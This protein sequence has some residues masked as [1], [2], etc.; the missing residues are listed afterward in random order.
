M[1]RREL[2][3]RVKERQEL[4]RRE[5]R[6][7]FSLGA[8]G[9]PHSDPDRQGRRIIPVETWTRTSGQWS[10][11]LQPGISRSGKRIGFPYG[12]W[13]RWIWLWMVSTAKLTGSPVIDLGRSANQFLENL[14][15]STGGNSHARL[16]NHLTRMAAV[17]VTLF[18]GP[19]DAPG[20]ARKDLSVQESALWWDPV[21]P[22][23][24]ELFGSYLEL[25]PVLFDQIQRH[26]FPFSWEMVRELGR[27]TTALD[28]Y[29]AG[30]YLAARRSRPVLIR[31]E[32]L[33]KELGQDWKPEALHVHRRRIQEAL[34]PVVKKWHTSRIQ[35]QPEGILFAALGPHVPRRLKG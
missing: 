13:A 10:L 22:D 21:N 33:G 8:V 17:R 12:P 7:G 30:T 6:I 15:K 31:W 9:W 3:D 24:G 35:I 2:K 19:V 27:N 32:D 29:L 28:L 4:A 20:E 25:N 1:D 11:Q 18:A 34:V 14:G 16:R 23:Q 26:A 5:S